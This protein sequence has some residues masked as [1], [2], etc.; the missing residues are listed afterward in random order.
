MNHRAHRDQ[1]VFSDRIYRMNR[2][3]QYNAKALF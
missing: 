3:K 1:G 2:M